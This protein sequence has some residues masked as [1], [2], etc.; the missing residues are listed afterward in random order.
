MEAWLERVAAIT[1]RMTF[2]GGEWVARLEERLA[3]EA[4]VA[5]TVGC[6]NG[7]DALQLALRDASNNLLAIM[8]VEDAFPWDRDATAM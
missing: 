7:T 3:R 8:T 4:D 6:A 2:V 5:H 1:A